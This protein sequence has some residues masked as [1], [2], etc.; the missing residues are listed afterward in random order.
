MKYLFYSRAFWTLIISR[1]ESDVLYVDL[2]AWCAKLENQKCLEY[3]LSESTIFQRYPN[4]TWDT[5]GE[6]TIS[7]FL[8]YDCTLKQTRSFEWI[9]AYVIDGQILNRGGPTIKSK[10]MIG[11]LDRLPA[12][13]VKDPSY[14]HGTNEMSYA[15]ACHSWRTHEGRTTTRSRSWCNMFKAKL[16]VEHTAHLH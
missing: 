6:T 16:F 14:F 11:N 13:Q 9:R 10:A 1:A 3:Y 12:F 15:S 5:S 7:T 4:D 8:L 2:S